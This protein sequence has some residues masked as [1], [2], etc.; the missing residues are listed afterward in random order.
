MLEIYTLRVPTKTKAAKPQM[1]RATKPRSPHLQTGEEIL[2]EACGESH[3]A[4]LTTSKGDTRFQPKVPVAAAPS[5]RSTYWLMMGCSTIKEP[6]HFSRF[7]SIKSFKTSWTGRKRATFGPVEYIYIYR[8]QT[9][10][11]LRVS[12]I[13]PA[14][15]TAPLRSSLL[16]SALK[17]MVA[18]WVPTT[19]RSVA[20]S[21]RQ[22]LGRNYSSADASDPAA[23]RVWIHRK[24][25][26]KETFNKK[27]PSLSICCESHVS[28]D[29]ANI[30]PEKQQNKTNR[31]GG[32]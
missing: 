29:L 31:I 17:W 30:D 27:F 4:V 18:I 21:C 8:T 24:T 10:L 20:G 15:A 12:I 19:R 7:S 11:E 5:M 13:H 2:Q 14:H 6:A 25:M 1:P 22:S 23:L 16:N 3:D 28:K 26:F 32:Q 9:F